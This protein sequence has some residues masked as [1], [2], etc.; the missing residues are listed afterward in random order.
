MG[1][2]LGKSSLAKL[3]T[4][5]PDLQALTR[6][7]IEITT[8]DFTVFEGARTLERQKAL[9]ASGASRTLRSRHLTGDAV[10]L[11]PWLDGRPVWDVAACRQIAAAMKQ[12]SAELQ[13]PVEWGGDWKGFFD[14]P[15]FQRP[16]SAK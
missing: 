13:I 2:H 1:F 5:H 4:V 7:A 14:G 12:A 3:A 15:H 6:R 16:W 9:V 8:V 11:V 10:D